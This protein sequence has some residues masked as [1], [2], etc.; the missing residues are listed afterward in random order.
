[1]PRFSPWRRPGAFACSFPSDAF[2]CVVSDDGGP[3]CTSLTFSS[4]APSQKW[5]CPP[6]HCGSLF[7]L[8]PW[9]H[10]SITSCDASP[11]ALVLTPACPLSCLLHCQAYFSTYGEVVD[12]CVMIDSVSGRPRGFGFVSFAD[13]TAVPLVT[14]AGRYHTIN[15]R[16]VDVKPAIPRDVINRVDEQNLCT[17]G[18]G[19]AHSLMQPVNFMHEAYSEAGGLPMAPLTSCTP[20]PSPH[21]MHTVGTGTGSGGGLVVPAGV[22]FQSFAQPLACTPA[23][24]T[25]SFVPPS[26][27]VHG[28]PVYGGYMPAG[29]PTMPSPMACT[30]GPAQI[31]YAA[32]PAYAPSPGWVGVPMLHH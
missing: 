24:I 19:K 16:E 25:P 27:I 31:G 11:R 14:N 3:P 30:Y 21:L 7:A 18:T 23:M 6:R 17:K 15:E 8:N 10:T 5:Q 12:A 1:M 20:Y 4:D 2:S 13:A 32:A 28:V 29:T 22:P 9:P 26:G